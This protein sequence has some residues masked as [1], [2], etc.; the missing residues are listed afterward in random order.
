MKNEEE[1]NEM[2]GLECS[3][4]CSRDV[5]VDS[6]RQK[7]KKKPLKCGYEE[8]WRRSAGLIKSLMRKFSRE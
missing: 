7:K 2:L 8:E 5:D 1:N 3:T 6:D 4:V